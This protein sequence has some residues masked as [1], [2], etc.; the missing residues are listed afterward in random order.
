VNYTIRQLGLDDVPAYRAI[1]LEA[2]RN[3]PEAFASDY[4]TAVTQP[5]SYF[6]ALIANLAFFGAFV[7][8]ELVGIVAFDQSAGVREAHRGWLYQM[9]VQP[10]MRGTGCA[11]ALIEH[12]LEHARSIVLQIHL[13][14]AADNAV[15]L[16][17]Y[18]KAGFTIYG[19]EPR[20]MYV[21]GRYIDEHLMVRFFDKAPGD[22]K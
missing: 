18:R 7:G 16:A 13:G 2:L 14:V 5:D 21:N 11:M 9:Y 1:R 4:E 19:T 15:A 17:L 12:L 20:Y 6:T 3:H 10:Q 8:N 22:Q